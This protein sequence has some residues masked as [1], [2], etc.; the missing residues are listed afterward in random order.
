MNRNESIGLAV[1][2]LALVA[3]A[4]GVK[5]NKYQLRDKDEVKDTAVVAVEGEKE[6]APGKALSADGKIVWWDAKALVPM[7]GQAFKDVKRPYDRLPAAA[8]GRVTPGVYNQAYHTS[9]LC[10]RF[11]T[12]ARTFKLR[13]SLVSPGLALGH[14]PASGV[15]GLDMYVYAKDKGRWIPRCIGIPSKQDGNVKEV[16]AYPGTPVMIYLPLY[17]GVKKLEIGLGPDDTIKPLPP[18]ASGI[19]KPVV[20]Y[21]TSITHGG[22]ASRPGMSFPAIATR[23]LDVPLVNLGF[24]GNGKME[25]EMCDYCARIDASCYVLDCIWNMTPDMIKERFEPFVRELRKRRPGV[26][27]ILA[28]DCQVH[29][30]PG[31][32]DSSKGKLVKE[33]YEKLKAEDAQLWKNLYLLRSAGQFAWDEEGTVDGAHPNDWGMMHMARAFTPVIA[34]AL[35]LKWDGAPASWGPFDKPGK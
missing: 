32:E 26:P 12:T 35:H 4:E 27:I 16:F 2:A 29:L 21:G 15:S 31:Q 1:A 13:W 18:R 20:F 11:A 14:M 23:G 10:L 6:I 9:G 7:E 22:V 17:N 3:S 34:E 25:M 19:D 8:Q 24:S 30:A 5:G 28:E 33:A